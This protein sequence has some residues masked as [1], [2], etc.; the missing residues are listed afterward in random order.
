MATGSAINSIQEVDGQL[1]TYRTLPH[2]LEAEQ[3]LLGAILI[4]NEALNQVATFLEPPHFYL[5]VHGRIFE[6]ILKMIE[7]GQ[8]ASPVTLKH[9][10]DN[11]DSLSDVGGAQYLAR[12]AGSAVTIINAEHYGRAIYDLAMR[13]ELIGIGEEM[14]NEAYDASLD[15]SATAQIENSEHKLFKLAEEG[16]AEG[17]FRSFDG[18]L[19][20]ALDMIT[21]ACKRD[22]HLSGTSTG[23]MDMDKL[24]GY[25]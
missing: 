14:V 3:A 21:Q 25:R 7:R 5:P 4:N 10:F 16:G 22:G 11:D 20:I 1:P 19:R 13:R 17:G 23:F 8:I 9:Y 2:N 24:L 6:A 15:E 12:L 18:P